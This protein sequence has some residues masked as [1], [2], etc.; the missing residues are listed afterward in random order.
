MKH[1]DK[2]SSREPTPASPTQHRCPTHPGSPMGLT[3]P[4]S[5]SETSDRSCCCSCLPHLVPSQFRHEPCLLVRR[6]YKRSHGH[7]CLHRLTQRKVCGTLNGNTQATHQTEEG[8]SPSSPS[9]SRHLSTTATDPVCPLGAPTTNTTTIAV[10]RPPNHSHGSH[11]PRG[12][13]Q[14]TTR[15]PVCPPSILHITATDYVSH[16]LR[17]STQRPFVCW[18]HNYNLPAP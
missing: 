12:T 17:L 10:Q 18:Y 16:R 2:P 1:S 4:T 13:F 11:L 6:P 14:I 15:D 9:H 7:V 8:H 5:P 3:P